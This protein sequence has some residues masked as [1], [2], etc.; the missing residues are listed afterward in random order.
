MLLLQGMG[1]ETARVM[2]KRGAKVILACRDEAKGLA[3]LAVLQLERQAYLGIEETVA[4]SEPAVSAEVGMEEGEKRKKKKKSHERKER[5][6]ED[7]ADEEVAS[8]PSETPVSPSHVPGEVDEV[9][10]DQL[11]AGSS[12]VVSATKATNVDLSAPEF[13]PLDLAS[14]ASIRAFA[15]T[16]LSKKIPLNILVNN[17][18]A[19]AT[20]YGQ[21][22]DGLE[23]MFGVGQ[24]GHFLLTGLLIDKMVQSAEE[25][26]IPSRVVIL[27]STAAM[28][29]SRDVIN[30]PITKASA[31]SKLGIYSELKLANG[32]FAMELQRRL[33]RFSG[34]AADDD[35]QKAKQKADSK[36]ASSAPQFSST[37]LA[38]DSSAETASPWSST[39]KVIVAAVHPGI[40]QTEL[41]NRMMPAWFFKLVAFTRK[42][43]PQGAATACFVACHPSLETESSGGKYWEDSAPAKPTSLMNSKS[44]AQ[45]LWVHCSQLTRCSVLPQ[46]GEEAIDVDPLNSEVLALTTASPTHEVKD[47]AAHDIEIVEEAPKSATDKKRRK[48]KKNTVS[49]TT[50]EAPSNEEPQS[51]PSEDSSSTPSSPKPIEEEEQHAVEKE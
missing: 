32:L 40:V 9:T 20:K 31:F 33:D 21:T 14:F 5:N 46:D 1:L 42:T 2:V 8:G 51:S 27:T 22:E 18:S 45:K 24:V 6:E 19:M 26:G 35:K 36:T 43:V 30:H 38:Q 44:L 25:S 50:P 12:S 29:G 39:R 47:S 34:Y 7:E 48:K 11:V 16:F 23:I 17:A 4:P 10:S 28:T 13:I 41:S 49:Q 37:D 15:S 3:A